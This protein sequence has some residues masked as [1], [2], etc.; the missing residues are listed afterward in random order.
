MGNL[1]SEDPSGIDQALTMFAELEDL[2]AIDPFP[3][4]DGACIMKGVGQNMDPGVPPWH[5]PPIEPNG[6]VTIVE[7]DDAHVARSSYFRASK[8][9]LSNP[10]RS[11]NNRFHENK[12]TWLT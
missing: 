2:S 3:F 8:G 11:S 5:Q 10:Q 1:E 6:A 7:R 12:S 4:E 9:S